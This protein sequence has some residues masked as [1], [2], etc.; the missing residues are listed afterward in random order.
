MDVCICVYEKSPSTW[1]GASFNVCNT[2]KR[3]NKEI[4]VPIGGVLGYMIMWFL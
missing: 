3:G 1:G 4:L 2:V